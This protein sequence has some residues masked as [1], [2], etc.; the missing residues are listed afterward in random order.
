MKIKAMKH[1]TPLPASSK[2]LEFKVV[3][4]RKANPA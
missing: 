1:K 3:A 2:V 4:L